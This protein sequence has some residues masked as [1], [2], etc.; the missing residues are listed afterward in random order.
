M[1]T[2]R[3]RTEEIEKNELYMKAEE[4][5]FVKKNNT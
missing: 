5:L 1:I 3:K 4:T 2:L